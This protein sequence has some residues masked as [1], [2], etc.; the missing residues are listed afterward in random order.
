MSW[1]KVDAIAAVAASTV[2]SSDRETHQV[3]FV[4]NEG[5][6]LPNCSIT[7]EHEATV[8]D[9]QPNGRVIAIGWADGKFLCLRLDVRK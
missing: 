7:H 2:D 4:N 9:W 8:F 3:V 6:L 1:S 5:G